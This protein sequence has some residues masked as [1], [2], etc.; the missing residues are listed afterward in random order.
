MNVLITGTSTG[1]GF[2]A[3]KTLTQAGHTVFAT[4][5]G[6]EGKNRDNAASLRD[7]TEAHD[8]TLHLIELDVTSDPSVESAVAKALELEGAIDAVVNN[9]G[10]GC[11]GYAESLTIDQFQALFDTN[12]FGV[13]RV[14][15]AVLPHMRER[16]SG[17][18]VHVSSAIGRM[19]FPFISA[20]LASKWALEGLGLFQETGGE[21]DRLAGRRRGVD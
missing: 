3:A 8:G 18:L 12:L 21:H 1:F 20:Y 13:Q 5:R 7:A 16:G 2:L 15:R 19:V 17:L 11:S 10:Y 14:N 9:A 6:L 4:M